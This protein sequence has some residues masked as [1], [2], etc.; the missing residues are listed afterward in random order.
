M[1]ITYGSIRGCEQAPDGASLKDKSLDDL[2]WVGG[3]QTRQASNLLV[4][5]DAEH[6]AL[7]SV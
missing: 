7:F 4:A 5:V 1:K 3:S 6:F 2:S